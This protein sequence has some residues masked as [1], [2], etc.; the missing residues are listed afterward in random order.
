MNPFLRRVV[1]TILR[2]FGYRIVLSNNGLLYAKNAL[3]RAIYELCT[4]ADEQGIEKLPLAHQ[5]VVRAWAALG[6]IGNGGF[7]YFYEGA[8]DMPGVARAFRVFGFEEA[9]GACEK[10]LDIFPNRLPERDSE[11]RH[12]ILEKTDFDAYEEYEGA[13]YDLEF[14]ALQAAIGAYMDRHPEEFESVLPR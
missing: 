10:S 4:R 8:W 14:G 9:A 1:G 6:I 13:V 5:H 2:P 11:R 3:E 12:E 7:R